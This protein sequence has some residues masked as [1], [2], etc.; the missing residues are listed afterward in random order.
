[1]VLKCTSGCYRVKL[2]ESTLYRLYTD[3]SDLVLIKGLYSDTYYVTQ[4]TRA[5]KSNIVNTSARDC[6]ERSNAIPTY[7]YRIMIDT[8]WSEGLKCNV[9]AYNINRFLIN[10]EAQLTDN[11]SFKDIIVNKPIREH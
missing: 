3:K 4:V 8:K 11:F 2:P 7:L 1:M 6:S 10:V 5:H 9:S